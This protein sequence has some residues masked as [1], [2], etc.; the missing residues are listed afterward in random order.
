[1][2]NVIE[3][4]PTVIRS[5]QATYDEM[6]T[7][8]SPCYHYKKTGRHA[9]RYVRALLGRIERKNG[10]QMAEY[11]GDKSPHA[12]QNFLSRAAWDS[13]KVRDTLMQ[14][15]KSHLLSGD[16][17][18]VII[19]DET[20][21]LKKG[22]H[23]A[24]VSRQYSGTAGRIENSQIGVFLTLASNKGR[25]L[26]DRELYLPKV[27]CDDKEMRKAAHIP[28]DISFKTKLQLAQQMLERVYAQGIQPEWVLGDA[29]Y[30]SYGFRSF[31]EKHH[32]PYVI[33]VSSQQRLWIDYEQVRIDKIA[34]SIPEK[35]WV[36]HSVGSGTKGERVYDWTSWRIGINDEINNHRYALVRRSVTNPN[37]YSYYFCYAAENTS[38]QALAAAAGKRWNIE[39]CFETAKQETG[40]DEYEVRS[41]QGWYRHITLSMVAL[42]Y[43]SVIRSACRNDEAEKGG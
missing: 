18:G 31:L 30:G 17:R 16:E 22:S 41:W 43:L 25:A 32:Q 7:Q 1:M 21:F 2:E 23:S 39:C 13:D 36:K 38:T 20:G 24:G 6:W 9:E 14:Y 40:L 33:G 37:E 15:L 10:W 5:W 42:A 34:K 27:W 8:F 26:L 28:N 29:V 4:T 11:L 35:E 19:V 12:I 3:Q